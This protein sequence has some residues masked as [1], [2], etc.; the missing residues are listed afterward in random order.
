MI[1]FPSYGKSFLLFI[2]TSTAIFTSLFANNAHFGSVPQPHPVPRT[3]S[4]NKPCTTPKE[5]P[6]RFDWRPAALLKQAVMNLESIGVEITLYRIKG[7]G[8]GWSAMSEILATQ[9]YSK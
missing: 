6:S 7:K 8:R 2:A 1:I 9:K 3:G 4:P 5:K